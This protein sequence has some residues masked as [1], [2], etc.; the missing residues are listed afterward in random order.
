MIEAYR[1]FGEIYPNTIS[2]YLRYVGIIL[3]KCAASRCGQQLAYSGHRDTKCV[4]SG[5]EKRRI[6]WLFL[7][8]VTTQAHMTGRV[9]YPYRKV[10]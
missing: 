10:I 8:G 7:L 5:Y 9:N 4:R 2:E 1:R 3:Q 6:N